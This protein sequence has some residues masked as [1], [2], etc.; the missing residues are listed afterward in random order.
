[1]AFK[2][3]KEEYLVEVKQGKLRKLLN[4]PGDKKVD[5]VY[6]SG[7]KLAADL[8]KKVKYDAAIR[9]LVFAANMNQNS[10]VF[11]SAVNAIKKMK[12]E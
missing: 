5:E 8:M 7:H 3:L 11:K 2:D 10:K 12:P 6:T 1:M 9:M 4:I